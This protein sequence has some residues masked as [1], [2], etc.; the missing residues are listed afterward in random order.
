MKIY[1]DDERKTPDGWVRTYTAV[2]TIELLRKGEATHLSLDHDLGDDIKYGTG[3]T[4]IKWL[5]EMVYSGK[6]EMAIPHI[7]IHSQNPVGIDNMKRGLKSILNKCE[8]EGYE[9][10]EDE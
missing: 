7:T 8:M 4:V 2:D 10:N 6:P 5:E 9:V 1:L 3:Y